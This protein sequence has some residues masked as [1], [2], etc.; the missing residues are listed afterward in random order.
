L[1]VG[2]SSDRLDAAAP[3]DADLLA[4]LTLTPTAILD[5]TENTALLGWGFDSGSE[6]FDYLATG[7][8]LV[9]TYTVQA[10]DDDGTPLN[11]TETITITITGTNDA[12]IITDG[13]DTAD[14]DETNAALS[15][16]GTLTVSDVDTTD[17]VTASHTLAVTGSSDRLDAA[18]P[19]DADLL[20]ML[21]LTPTAILD[22]TE[23]TASLGWGFDSGSETFDYLA[24]GE[25]LVLTYTVQA[26]DDDGTPLNDTETITIT[27]TGTND[28][29]VITDGPDAVDLD[30]T[31]AALITSG[32]VTI[33]DV[34]TTD[35]VTASIDSLVVSGSSDRLDAAAPNDA[36]L[37]AMFS[38]NPTAILD[39]TE[40]SNTLNWSFNSG[41]EAF[42]YLAT[43]ETLILTYTIG[44]TDDDGTPLSDTITV[45]ITITGSND[46]PVITG[47]PDTA[48]IAETSAGISTIGSLTIN[49]VDTTDIVNANVDNLVVSGTSNR[50]DPA[51]PSDAALLAMLNINPVA[52]LDAT[53]NSDTLS[54]TFD[55]GVEAFNY[56]A[57]GETL[58]LQYT[59]T[60]TDDDGTP[61]LD[62][63]TV[64]I[65]ITGTN[66]APVAVDASAG[67]LENTI[68]N[69]NVPSA[70][71]VDGTIVSYAIGSTTVAEG[72][73]TFNADGSYSFDPGTDFDDL[74]GGATRDVTFTYTAT[75]NDGAVSAEQTITITVTGIN[76][77]PVIGG[78]NTGTVN[79]DTAV[80][81]GSISA[82]GRLTIQDLDIGE[83]SFV[84]A[85][86]NGAYG[87]L[88]I[89]TAGNWNYSADNDNTDIQVLLRDESLVETLTVTTADGSTYDIVIT[90]NGANEPDPPTI[91][92]PETPDNVPLAVDEPPS[93][94]TQLAPIVSLEIAESGISENN[95]VPQPREVRASLDLDGGVQLAPSAQ[96]NV[97]LASSRDSRQNYD[98]ESVQPLDWLV[99]EDSVDS[100]GFQVSD[101]EELNEQFENSL[102]ARL[103]LMRQ[104]IDGD[105][106]YRK[107]D[108]VKVQITMGV[109]TSLT[110][111]IVSWV[112]RSGSLLASLMSA[113]PLLNRFD[114]L[115]ILKAR[116]DEEDVE[117]DDDD[118]ETTIP[119]NEHQKRVE[120]MFSD[121]QGSPP[122]S[123]SVDE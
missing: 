70:S 90:I 26:A 97:T 16:A 59:A 76:D 111:G 120:N 14:L 52:I 64:T 34:D 28:A 114:M 110:A 118:T 94:E 22:G 105:V 88:V 73:L 106:D 20:A 122:R 32:D 103:D 92:L 10:T 1:A 116:D 119:A 39:G 93:Q 83:S 51:A 66:D 55:S 9:L 4:M 100:L 11:D 25:T 117:P 95:L 99:E 60:A 57:I 68:L 46:A 42:D 13:P 41:T 87:N 80:I 96:Q 101:D 107:A 37:L 48:G 27:I 98:P 21:T 17:V 18:A 5:S 38:I 49:D 115:P 74:V 35:V 84:A 31:N 3:S 12:P 19:S 54:W 69:G 109:S 53:E 29:P 15:A 78:V 36:V 71:D 2:G 40:N 45:T 91:N 65:T 82:N 77:P 123:G 23:N 33:G 85:T 24:T 8:T 62:T 113:V 72:L 6:T 47:G 67:T 50:A 63:E 81:N 43:G 104:G 121:S 61:L 44:A 86:I 89:D 56:L 30:E 79:E 112:L 102:L 58:I 7:E 75:D 108:D